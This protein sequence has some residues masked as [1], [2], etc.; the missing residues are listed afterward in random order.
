VGAK[1]IS[2]SV[3]KVNTFSDWKT[4]TGLTCI[5]A[6]FRE[7]MLGSAD[8]WVAAPTLPYA[9]AFIFSGPLPYL[10]ASSHLRQAK[11]PASR[12]SWGQNS[13]NFGPF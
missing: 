10:F 11:T 1:I 6:R 8:S 13:W 7:R 12:F 2:L 3:G 9:I 5:V 4:G